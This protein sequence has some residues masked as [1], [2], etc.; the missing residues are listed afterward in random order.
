LQEL[1]NQYAGIRELNELKLVYSLFTPAG[2]KRVVCRDRIS[3]CH[4]TL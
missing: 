2:V 3:D 4:S 1:L